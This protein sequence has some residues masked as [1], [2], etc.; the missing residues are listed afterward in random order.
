M[1]LTDDAKTLIRDEVKFL[2]QKQQVT[3]SELNDQTQEF[4]KELETLVKKYQSTLDEL[5]VYKWTIRFILAILGI[6]TIWAFWVIPEYVDSRIG[7]RIAKTDRIALAVSLANASRWR[8]S[9]AIMSSQWDDFKLSGF[10]PSDDYKR[11]FFFNLLWALAECETIEPD[12]TWTGEQLWNRLNSDSD[13]QRFRT[14]GDW[15]HD[16]DANYQLALCTLK[17]S[18]AADSLQTARRYFDKALRLADPLMRRASPLHSL[19]MI[20]LIDKQLDVAGEK[21]REAETIDP[22]NY[23]I[24]DKI[25]YKNSFVNS[26]E[27]R[28]WEQIS[29][30]VGAGE[31]LSIYD[32]LLEGASAKEIPNSSESDKSLR[33]KGGQD[34]RRSRQ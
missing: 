33:G 18:K 9:L 23:K 22:A 3:L 29:R 19:A 13:Y 34:A 2:T 27:F 7:D 31:F 25:I 17:Y 28:L 4:N 16:S 26:T 1:D 21:L 20:D 10:K 12:G 24:S 30:K 5:R 6:G 15:D 8:D 11:F 32:E 14:A